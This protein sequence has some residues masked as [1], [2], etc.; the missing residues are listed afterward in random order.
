MIARRAT[1]AGRVQGVG[2]R[3]FAERTARELGVT[4]W[5]RNLPDGKVESIAEGE[6]DLVTRYLAR[7]REGPR[8]SRVTEVHVEEVEVNGFASFEIT[9]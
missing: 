3:F 7:L 2:F 4:G 5:V 6:E 9:G 1:V 8:M